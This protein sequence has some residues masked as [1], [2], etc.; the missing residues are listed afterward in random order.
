MNQRAEKAKVS[1]RICRE[2]QRE[3]VKRQEKNKEISE[4]EKFGFDKEIQKVVDESNKKI[5]SIVDAK[6]KQIM[7]I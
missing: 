7:T 5:V 6:E 4:N 1:V 2:Q 3:I